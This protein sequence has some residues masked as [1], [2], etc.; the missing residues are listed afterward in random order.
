[1]HGKNLF[2]PTNF[3]EKMMK[4]QLN[5]S[6]EV[7][8]I[9]LKAGLAFQDGFRTIPDKGD[10]SVSNN[11]GKQKNEIEWNAHLSKINVIKST[12]IGSN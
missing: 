1:M 11:P 3:V 4:L 10:Y 6:A 5:F 2:R 12:G 7:A 9:A 8:L